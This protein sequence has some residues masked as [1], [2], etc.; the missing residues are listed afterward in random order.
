MVK[1]LYISLFVLSVFTLILLGFGLLLNDNEKKHIN[2]N[3]QLEQNKNQQKTIPNTAIVETAALVKAKPLSTLKNSINLSIITN[4]LTCVSD[5]QCVVV[6]AKFVD[7]TCDVAVN[8][9]GAAQLF[10]AKKDQTKI[11][12]CPE[13]F[14]MNNAI[15]INNSC[16]LEAS[17]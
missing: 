14:K 9:V 7:F 2:Y 3:Q 12:R 17:N 8:I 1:W 15:C 13:P 10:K 16:S 4:N 5:E 11:G 6:K